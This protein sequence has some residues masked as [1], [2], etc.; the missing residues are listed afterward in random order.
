M[1]DRGDN[2]CSNVELYVM[3]VKLKQWGHCSSIYSLTTGSSG[4]G[5]FPNKA[6]AGFIDRRVLEIIFL[7]RVD[8]EKLSVFIIGVFIKHFYKITFSLIILP[9]AQILEM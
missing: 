4:L 3:S 8:S 6:A 2:F 1:T 5:M 9:S 7:P